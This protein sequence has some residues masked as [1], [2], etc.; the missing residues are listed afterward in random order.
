MI[1]TS[2]AGAVTVA[3]RCLPSG[4]A[5]P[6]RWTLLSTARSAKLDLLRL[7]P[8]PCQH[9]WA[10]R[11]VPRLHLHAALTCPDLVVVVVVVAASLRLDSRPVLLRP[12]SRRHLPSRPQ[13]PQHRVWLRLRTNPMGLSLLAALLSLSRPLVGVLSG[14]ATSCSIR[15]TSWKGSEGVNGDGDE[16]DEMYDAKLVD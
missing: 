11:L 3:R 2:M 8:P 16:D 13:T 15:S 6:I 4:T 9:H 12:I 10:R 14:R 5:R 1:G 7:P